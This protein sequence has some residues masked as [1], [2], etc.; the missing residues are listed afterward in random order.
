M[1]MIGYHP[2]LETNLTRG[3]VH[4]FDAMYAKPRAL[5]HAV[6]GT[7]TPI[8]KLLFPLALIIR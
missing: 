3:H 1:P 4:H 6:S 8:N 5:A 2:D 7:K